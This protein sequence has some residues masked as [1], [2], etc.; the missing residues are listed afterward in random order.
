MSYYYKVLRDHPIGF[1]KLDDNS[2][3]A[4]DFSGCG[5]NGTYTGQLPSQTKNMPLVSG[6]DYSAK[7]TSSSY[8]E[9]PITSDYYG[10]E[11]SGGFATI[12][13]SDNDFTIECWILPKISS[14]N[15]TAVLADSVN[16]VGIFWQNNNIVFVI[17]TESLEYTL[18]EINKSLYI[19]C[20]YSVNSAS[21]YLNG[22]LVIS[23]AIQSNPFENI[24]TIL[25]AGPTQDIGDEFL[26]DNIA[27][28]RYALSDKKIKEHYLGN[29]NTISI[30]VAYPDNG[31]I[32]NIYDNN[33][34]TS[35]VYNYPK[36]KSWE[37]FLTNDLSLNRSENYIEIAKT[38]SNNTKEII[39]QDIISMPS[40][41]AM[42]SSKIEWDGST[43]VSVYTSLDGV[44]Y[45]QC[46]N[47]YPIPQ[48]TYLDFNE[49]KFIHI[50]IV[51][52]SS[53]SSRYLPKLYSLSIS[54]Y[55]EQILYSKN[56][57]SYISKIEDKDY[58]LGK[59][60]YPILSANSRNG[61]YVP[62]NSGFKI[63]VLYDVNSI[64]FF[65]IPESLQQSLLISASNT[66]LKWASNGTVTK[67]NILK[68]YVNGQDKST[69]TNISNIMTQ[70]YLNHVVI[71]LDNP[72]T[73][74]IIFNYQSTSS[75][76][77]CYQHISLYK[78][79]MEY[80]QILNHYSLYTGRSKYTATGSTM[81]MTE[82][83]TNL[84]NNDWMV[85]QNS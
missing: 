67:N 8:I 15:L 28:Y 77:A 1:W 23:K 81:A 51:M 70:G 44:S 11:P 40:G 14:T 16:D 5:N 63:N 58:M 17:G 21:I 59:E 10:Q 71:V 33:I 79:A 38:E 42:D 37:Y 18:P 73:G 65:Y 74:E 60:V 2:T 43:G 29:E 64:E 85:I 75:V 82:N 57:G 56:G 26:I 54:F 22:N 3:E 34:R 7:I 36:D 6:G 32:F 30:Q 48:Y 76:P 46:T 35:F 20:K 50:K 66:L 4:V 45:E 39:I 47:G 69:E 62:E 53:N 52:E 84:Y 61:V 12:Y 19:V 83:S 55:S 27:V 80:N 68:I 72:E 13:T 31:E 41:I 9:F 78:Y 49:Q 25:K 24:D